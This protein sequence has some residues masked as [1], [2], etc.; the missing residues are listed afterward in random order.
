MKGA[1]SLGNGQRSNLSCLAAFT[2]YPVVGNHSR[3]QAAGSCLFDRENGLLTVCAWDPRIHGSFTHQL[4]FSISLVTI[5]D[6]IR[7]VKKLR[8]MALC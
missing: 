3:L 5:S 1:L 2:G 7:D 4:A 6:F 8:D